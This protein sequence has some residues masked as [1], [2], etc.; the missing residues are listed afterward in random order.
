MVNS[1]ISKKKDQRTQNIGKINSG[2]DPGKLE[3]K[4]TLTRLGIYIMFI[5]KSL[6]MLIVSNLMELKSYKAQ[7]RLGLLHSCLH[8]SF[9]EY[10]GM[11]SQVVNASDQ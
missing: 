5:P 7:T 8:C 10:P 2:K 9:K 1:S 6:K 3:H 4:Y 11:Q